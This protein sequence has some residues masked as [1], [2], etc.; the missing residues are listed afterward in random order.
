MNGFFK[1][2][3]LAAV[4]ALASGQ[5]LNGEMEG[6]CCHCDPGWKVVNGVCS[7]CAEGYVY[8][9][10]NRVCSNGRP[11]APCRDTFEYPYFGCA[12]NGESIGKCTD[13]VFPC[14]CS[15]NGASCEKLAA[16]KS[17]CYPK[18]TRMYTSFPNE[19][20]VGYPYSL[21]FVG[22]QLEKED[23]YAVIP[24]FS[25]DLASERKCSSL[26]ATATGGIVSDCVFKDGKT[27]MLGNTTCSGTSGF[28]LKGLT[29]QQNGTTNG[30][31]EYTFQDITMTEEALVGSAADRKQGNRNSPRE[32]ETYFRVCKFTSV[33]GAAEAM[34]VA[35][36]EVA[37]HDSGVDKRDSMYK[38]SKSQPNDLRGAADDE[39]EKA[40]CCAG[41]K[42]GS[43][44]LPLWA[45][46]C[47]W[48]ATAVCIGGLGFLFFKNSKAISAHRGNE[49]YEKF[50]IDAEMSAMAAKQADEDDNF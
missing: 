20:R 19:A 42:L 16:A 44:C 50:N 15:A 17:P 27:A 41:L 36:V 49:K 35:W 46:L 14:D 28:I 5:C 45:F 6:T 39:E 12:V 11:G 34:D 3:V 9:S 48:V 13:G 32:K 29:E 25:D 18:G 1:P 7:E 47:L 10:K 23:Y 43:L 31:T 8:D 26:Q 40:S 24:A 38:I 2:L 21:T 30:L 22:C 4:L 33:L 37:N